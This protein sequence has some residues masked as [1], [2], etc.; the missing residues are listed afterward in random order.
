[1]DERAINGA[2]IE[3]IRD[4][5][6]DCEIK[7]VLQASGDEWCIQFSG[8]YGQ[9]CDAFKNQFGE[10]SSHQ[11][12]REK[13]KSHL[14]KQ[15]NKIRSGTGRKRKAMIS[16]PEEERA[17]AGGILA[18][19]L[20]LVGEV[21]ERFA[22]ITGIVAN[23]A[24]TAAEAAR[25]AVADRLTSGLPPLTVEVRSQTRRNTKAASGP[26]RKQS[27]KAATTKRATTKAAKSATT[28]RAATATAATPTARKAAKKTTKKVAGKTSGKATGRAQKAK[29]T[30]KP[31]RGGK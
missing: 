6:L 26:A 17:S 16:E 9:F 2:A 11:V 24:T 29:A 1:M 21:F 12:M 5:E 20:K 30:K 13:I 3:A 28:K 8:K 22:G 7:E 25:D 27:V 19:P 18:E 14:I 23:Q 10:E 15:I 31:A 4:L